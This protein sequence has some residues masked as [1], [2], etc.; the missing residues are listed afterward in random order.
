[1]GRLQSTQPVGTR[2]ELT[3]SFTHERPA[4]MDRRDRHGDRCRDARVRP[5]PQGDGL[6]IVAGL[7]SDALPIAA[8]NGVLLLIN[9]WGVWQYL[10]NPQ[11][12]KVIERVE[13]VAERIEREVEAEEA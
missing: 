8:M 7:T 1:M 5:W 10:L 2:Q 12:K 4:R 11:K 13:R 6:R 3:R 9:A